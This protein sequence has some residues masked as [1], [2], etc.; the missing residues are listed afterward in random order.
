MIAKEAPIKLVNFMVLGAKFKFIAPKTKKEGQ[1]PPLYFQDYV[2]DVDFTQ[3]PIDDDKFHVFA[4]IAVNDN[5]SPLPGYQI[6]V[7]GAA[8]FSIQSKSDISED[9]LNNLKYFSSINIVIGYLRSTINSLTV[10]APFGPYLLP[11]VDMQDL[12]K[13]KG[14]K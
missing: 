2:L 6:V 13:K 5:D 4:K 14:E 9:V 11:P 3:R 10:S 7:E 1:N 12:F 8:T